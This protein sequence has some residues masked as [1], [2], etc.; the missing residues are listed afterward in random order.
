MDSGFGNALSASPH[1][2]S[3]VRGREI[4]IVEYLLPDCLPVLVSAIPPLLAMS[5]C[6]LKLRLYQSLDTYLLIVPKTT[7]NGEFKA[8]PEV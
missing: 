6:L 5:N 7:E 2:F 4:I 8:S 1:R 3:Q